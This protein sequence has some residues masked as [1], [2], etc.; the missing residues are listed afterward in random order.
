MVRLANDDVRVMFPFIGQFLFASDGNVLD[1]NSVSWSDNR[2]LSSY[3][4]LVS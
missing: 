3:F 1:K 2:T 4:A